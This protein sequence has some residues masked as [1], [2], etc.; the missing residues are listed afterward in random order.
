MVICHTP[1]QAPHCRYL[2]RPEV[3]VY[4]GQV[5]SA[6]MTMGTLPEKYM[7]PSYNECDHG[8]VWNFDPSIHK[9]LERIL[10]RSQ[11]P[12]LGKQSV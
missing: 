4:P 9:R 8:I 10:A 11:D 1:L 2:L 7:S 6:F 12:S 5:D 3:S